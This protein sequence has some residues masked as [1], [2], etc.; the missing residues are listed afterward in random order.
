MYVMLYVT[1]H[2][3]MLYVTVHV[4]L[5]VTWRVGGGR[6][7]ALQTPSRKACLTVPGPW[8]AADR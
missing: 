4:T 1:V 7:Q 8:A 3:V 5:R 6:A 2:Y